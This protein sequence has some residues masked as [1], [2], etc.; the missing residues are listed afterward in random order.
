MGQASQLKRR[1][2]PEPM[3]RCDQCGNVDLFV[4]IMNH[5]SHLVDGQ[6]NYIRLMD[7]D[8]DH[9]LCHVCGEIVDPVLTQ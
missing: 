5:E 6:L 7:A 1:S 3:L 2:K 9:Y 4:E 8:V